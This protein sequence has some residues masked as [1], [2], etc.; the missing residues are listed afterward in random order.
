LRGNLGSKKGSTDVMCSEIQA[1]F[2]SEMLLWAIAVT[3]PHS[4]IK[5]HTQ[6]V[7]RRQERDKKCP[8]QKNE[9]TEAGSQVWNAKTSGRPKKN[10]EEKLF[11][12]WLGSRSSRKEEKTSEE[13]QE[14][15]GE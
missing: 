7:H 9:K 3:I 1:L 4:P 10:C 5:T 11:V 13:E 12:V 14:K 8:T 2:D 6:N 15:E